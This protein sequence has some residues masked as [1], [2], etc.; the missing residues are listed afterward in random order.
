MVPSRVRER[1][2]ATRR[3]GLH[4]RPV[5]PYQG[6]AFHPTRREVEGPGEQ[7]G[8]RETEEDG[9][10]QEGLNPLRKPERFHDDVGCLYQKPAHQRVG[11]SDPE[12][13]AAPELGEE[14]GKALTRFGEE[15]QRVILDVM[16]RVPK[17]VKVCGSSR[18]ISPVAE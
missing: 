16:S 18:Y 7:Y 2:I 15:C 8:H 4:R 1:G 6:S 13:P 14:P 12:H 17:A 10:D 5:V 11:G 3:R 9:H